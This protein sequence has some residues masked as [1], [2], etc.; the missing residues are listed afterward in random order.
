LEKNAVLASLDISAAFDTTIH[1]GLLHRLTTGFGLSGLARTWL[2]SH[3]SYRTQ[4]VYIG[5]SSSTVTTFLTGVPQGS[6]LGPLLFSAYVCS[7]SR[8]PA[9]C[10]FQHHLYADDLFTYCAWLSFQG[11]F[12]TGDISQATSAIGRWYIEN[13]MLM[14]A[15]KSAAGKR[16]S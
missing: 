11:T 2:K 5:S 13:D 8:I 16:D 10:G 4:A 9:E 7:L 1:D 6:V 3:L 14:N 15:F 12:N